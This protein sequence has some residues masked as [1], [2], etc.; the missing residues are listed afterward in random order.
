[1]LSWDKLK[2]KV[3]EHFCRATR[4]H[5]PLEVTLYHVVKQIDAAIGATLV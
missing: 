5:V 2:C 1:M 4:F 3:N